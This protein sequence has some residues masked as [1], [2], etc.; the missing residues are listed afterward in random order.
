M[1][2]SCAPYK[3]DFIIFHLMTVWVTQEIFYFK[4][5]SEI[6]AYCLPFFPW[7]FLYCFL[8]LFLF[9]FGF[10]VFGVLFWFIFILQGGIEV[11]EGVRVWVDKAGEKI[12]SAL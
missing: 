9:W 10:V 3:S 2:V 11:T 1:E 8:N 7:L 12:N 4:K 5:L 6:S